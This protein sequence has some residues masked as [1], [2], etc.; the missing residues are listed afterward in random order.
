MK[1]K[2]KLALR[3]AAV[4][5]FS[6][7]TLC[8]WTSFFFYL[9]LKQLSPGIAK[10][11]TILYGTT[12]FIGGCQL[13][14]VSFLLFR[15]FLLGFFEEKERTRWFHEMFLHLLSHKVGNFL[16]AQKIN[17]SILERNPSPE[18]LLRIKQGLVRM[19]KDFRQILALI[20][21]FSRHDIRRRPFNPAELVESVLEE[22][23]EG[24]GPYPESRFHLKKK[25]HLSTIRANILETR[26]MLLLLLENAFKYAG[27]RISI[28]VGSFR[29][30]PY[31]AVINDIG[32]EK[33]AGTGMGLIF[34]EKL[35]KQMK[36]RFRYG[37]RRKRFF[38]LFMW[39]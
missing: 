16:L 6:F 33:S 2:N 22:L 28:R 35:A 7:L 38:A 18:A 12:L 36:A 21:T 17:A 4:I 34:A 8:A 24:E 5:T 26:I 15:E 37:V 10:P 32:P 11:V 29:K 31:I 3:F 20:D 19:E 9:S 13:I 14:A 39:P 27:N 23:G 25:Y 1:E 30:R